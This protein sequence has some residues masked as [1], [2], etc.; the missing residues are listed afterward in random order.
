MGVL[1][2]TRAH[3]RGRAAL[4]QSVDP[5]GRR[6]TGRVF[7]GACPSSRGRRTRRRRWPSAASSASRDGLLRLAGR[8]WSGSP[9]DGGAALHRDLLRRLRG[10]SACG[11]ARASAARTVSGSTARSSARDD[12]RGRGA[13]PAAPGGDQRLRRPW[14]PPCPES[15]GQPDRHR[16]GNRHPPG[17]PGLRTPLRHSAAVMT[18]PRPGAAA[19]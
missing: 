4:F 2:S 9:P 15:A 8:V 5:A 12:G 11:S 7:E 14:L 19:G 16:T 3:S 10:W 18:G 13:L 1:W 17:R 6:L